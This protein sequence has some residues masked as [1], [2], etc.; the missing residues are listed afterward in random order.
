MAARA[1]IGAW[2]FMTG[3]FITCAAPRFIMMQMDRDFG[4]D[5]GR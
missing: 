4:S 2:C 3:H 1:R 5:L